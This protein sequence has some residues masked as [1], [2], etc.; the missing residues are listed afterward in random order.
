M[1]DPRA[2]VRIRLLEANEMVKPVKALATKP[3]DLSSIPETQKE[4]K[5]NACKLSSDFHTHA[6]TYTCSHKINKIIL[7]I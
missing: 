7:K 1:L 2:N 6:H 5:I 3:K 4:K